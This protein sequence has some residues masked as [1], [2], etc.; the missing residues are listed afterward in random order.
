MLVLISDANVLI[1]LEVGGIV[2]RIF[3][4]GATVAVPD[5]LYAEELQDQH[6]HY[7]T[8]GLQ[9]RPLSGEALLQVATWS[10][11]YPKPSRNDLMAFALAVQESG[12]LLTGD[13]DLRTAVAT[14]LAKRDGTRI[15]HHGTFWLLE[16]MLDASVLTDD[17]ARTA[18]ERMKNDG[19]RLP[20]DRFEDMM[21]RRNRK[22]PGTV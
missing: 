8:L 13:R 11:L 16:Q 21:R 7:V 4:L 2:E 10:Q 1:D 15:V 14:E 12:V 3:R 22:N 17:E 20:W 9:L 19:R 5:V 18:I 6:P